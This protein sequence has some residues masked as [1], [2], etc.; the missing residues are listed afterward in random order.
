[1]AL[2]LAAETAHAQWR[3]RGWGGDRGWSGGNSWGVGIGD[4]G[5]GLSYGRGYGYPNYG[6]YYGNRYSYY[7]SP[8]WGGSSYYPNSSYYTPSYAYGDSYT[9]P[10]YSSGTVLRD[11]GAMIRQA[12]YAPAAN[13]I[14]VRVLVPDANARVWI[15]NEAMSITGPERLF[16]SP[17]VEAGKTYIYHVKASWMDNGKEVTRERTLD[18]RAGQEFVVNFNESSSSP[19]SD[20]SNN[21]AP[22]T[23]RRN[24]SARSDSNPNLPRPP[25][26]GLLESAKPME[27]LVVSAGN[28]TL[29][30]TN[31]DGLNRQ[32]FT[33]GSEASITL[34]GQNAMLSDLREGQRIR[35]TS[36]GEGTNRSILKVEAR[37][38]K[39]SP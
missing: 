3:G 10:S 8:Y 38:K 27:Y 39:D 9:Y 36:K 5:I 22:L 30:V 26:P 15:E 29:V 31:A 12:S 21:N 28:G 23:E 19:S 25:E 35:V 1:M 37:A 33:V 16:Y 24:D 11:D 32:T 13:T 18:V 34:D 14:N 6:G 4:G 2:A 20:Q 7:G 17:P